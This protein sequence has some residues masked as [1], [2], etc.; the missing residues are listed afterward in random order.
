L[1]G[2][3]ASLIA[4]SKATTQARAYASC[5]AVLFAFRARSGFGLTTERVT[6]QARERGGKEIRSFV[7]VLFLRT[8]TPPCDFWHN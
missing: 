8:K 3:T 1:S 6:L 2:L 4:R 7:D 5:H